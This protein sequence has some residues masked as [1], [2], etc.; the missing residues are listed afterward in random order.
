[1]DLGPGSFSIHY[2]AVMFIFFRI[3][4]SGKEMAIPTTFWTRLPGIEANGVMAFP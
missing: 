3:A 4:D 1:M 2:L